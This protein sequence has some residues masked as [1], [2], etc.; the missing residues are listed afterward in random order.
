MVSLLTRHNAGRGGRHH[1]RVENN[2][3]SFRRNENRY[4]RN[5]LRGLSVPLGT[6]LLSERFGQSVSGVTQPGSS[7]SLECP[8]MCFRERL[9]LL[10][11]LLYAPDSG[12]KPIAH[13]KSVLCLTSLRDTLFP[14][15]RGLVG[16][17]LLLLSVSGFLACRHAKNSTV[18]DAC[19]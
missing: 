16:D 7:F 8:C 17:I 13:P 6:H 15:D 5:Q 9:L 11:A 12:R 18:P 3:S 19:H 4:I 2:R 1:E 14:V 10:T